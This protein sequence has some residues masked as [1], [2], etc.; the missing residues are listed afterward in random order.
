MKAKHLLLIMFWLCFLGTYPVNAADEKI[1]NGQVDNNSIKMVQGQLSD[2]QSINIKENPGIE[3]VNSAGQVEPETVSAAPAEALGS[4][5][6][7]NTN[8]ANP[9]LQ[10]AKSATHG[11]SIVDKS[12]KSKKSFELSHKTSK[13]AWR[14]KKIIGAQSIDPKANIKQS[15]KL[16]DMET[17]RRN[18]KE[19]RKKEL[20]S[21][22]AR[23]LLKSNSDE[24]ENAS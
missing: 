17:K 5:I 12:D 13:A 20:E 22:P 21:K 8:N 7:N 3:L 2:T 15:K 1:I 24:E 16:Q 18:R 4:T 6:I 9:A 23:K 11:V 19:S 14:K 10:P